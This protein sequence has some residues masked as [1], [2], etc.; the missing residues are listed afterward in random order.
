MGAPRIFLHTLDGR[1]LMFNVNEDLYA[2]REGV[3]GVE[4]RGEWH[5][6][7]ETMN[8]IE[9]IIRRELD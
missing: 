9:T 2:Q 6:V 4:I 1:A 7:R 8:E 5:P 3:V